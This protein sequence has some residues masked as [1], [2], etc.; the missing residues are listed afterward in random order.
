MSNNKHAYNSGDVVRCFVAKDW[1]S[2]ARFL[3]IKKYAETADVNQLSYGGYI[4]IKPENNMEITYQ[5]LVRGGKPDAS[6]K[7]NI[8]SRKIATETSCIVINLVHTKKKI[9]K[10]ITINITM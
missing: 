9:N 1:V 10:N 5:G 8:L 7:N 6:N 2:V 4:T 3:F